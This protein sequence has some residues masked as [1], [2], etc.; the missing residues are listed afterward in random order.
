M[1]AVDEVFAALPSHRRT[2]LD[3]LTRSERA[4]ADGVAA[5]KTN[6]QIAEDLFVSPRTVDAHLSHIYRKLGITTRAKLA[7]LVSAA[8]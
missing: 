5:G 8:S 1:A 3:A 6:R 4:V 2:P 7:V